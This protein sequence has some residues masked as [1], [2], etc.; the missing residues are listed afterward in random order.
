MLQKFHRLET[1]HQLTVAIIVAFAI[2]S[3]WRGVW[4]LMSLYLLPENTVLSHWISLFLGL[5]ILVVT[6]YTTKE[7]M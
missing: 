3:F 6:G 1:K 5:L 7:L 2:I 4:G